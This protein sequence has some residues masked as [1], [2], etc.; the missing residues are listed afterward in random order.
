M[1]AQ[2]F[3]HSKL[4][5]R[6]QRSLSL[7][8]ALIRLFTS[9]KINTKQLRDLQRSHKG[10]IPCKPAGARG[11]RNEKKANCCANNET[12]ERKQLQCKKNKQSAA[13]H[14]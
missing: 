11:K 6:T 4:Y 9:Q 5:L 3:V 14:Y 10:E 1:N 13:F 8:P 12:S 7:N 2:Y